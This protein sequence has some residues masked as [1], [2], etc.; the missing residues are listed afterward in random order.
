MD[1]IEKLKA[2][3][4]MLS[5]LKKKAEADILANFQILNEMLYQDVAEIQNSV[6]S[7]EKRNL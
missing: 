5:M 4:A 1:A 6:S 3:L 7:F 2:F